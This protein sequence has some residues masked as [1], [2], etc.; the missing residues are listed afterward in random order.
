MRVT[1][2]ETSTMFGRREKASLL[3]WDRLRNATPLS[4][5]SFR[6]L[7]WPMSGDTSSPKPHSSVWCYNLR[8]ERSSGQT[9]C[10]GKEP[11]RI[12]PCHMGAVLP[13]RLAAR[14]RPKTWRSP[15]TNKPP[16]R[17]QDWIHTKLVLQPQ[18]SEVRNQQK[19][20]WVIPDIW[21]LNI[22]L[23]NNHVQRVKIKQPPHGRGGRL[24]WEDKY[25]SD[26]H[27]A[28]LGGAGSGKCLQPKQE[29]RNL[30]RETERPG[31][32]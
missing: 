12:A 9:E 17:K 3:V 28:T 24:K 1:K 19:G 16:Y 6:E 7:I 32:P 15:Q 29:G 31:T 21:K 4:S 10:S 13:F 2:R 14:H 25:L 11:I 23:E 26:L 27:N 18:R 22:P 8:K 30:F 20:T 5:A